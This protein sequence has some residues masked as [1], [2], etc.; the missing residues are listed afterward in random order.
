MTKGHSDGGRE[1]TGGDERPPVLESQRINQ[2]PKKN[3]KIKSTKPVRG[4]CIPADS[5]ARL[6]T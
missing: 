5:S 4:D 3:K 2:A 1:V 6:L